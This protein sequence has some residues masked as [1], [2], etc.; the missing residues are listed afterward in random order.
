MIQ[1]EITIYTCEAEEFFLETLDR[2]LKK[3]RESGLPAFRSWHENGNLWEEIYYLHGLKHRE[4]GLPEIRN[5]GI[6]GNH[7]SEYY[8]RNGRLYCKGDLPAL[9][10]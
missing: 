7:F 5:W 6:D 2:D 4:G 10:E 8:Y 3:H 1:H 9:S